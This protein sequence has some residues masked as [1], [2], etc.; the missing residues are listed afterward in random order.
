M[1]TAALTDAD[2]TIRALRHQ[3]KRAR[4]LEANHE[5]RGAVLDAIR[6]LGLVADDVRVALHLHEDHADAA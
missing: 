3:L 1:S 5:A 4:D 6:L 2:A